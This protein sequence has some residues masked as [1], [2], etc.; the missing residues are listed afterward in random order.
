MANYNNE[1]AVDGDLSY[2]NLYC[3]PVPVIPKFVDIVVNGLNDRLF[4]VN[5]FAEDAISAE[6]RDEFQKM[7]EVEMIARPLFQQIEQDFDLNLFK[8]EESE[9]PESDE[10]LQLYM[11]LKY[12][13]AIEIAAEEAIDTILN[14]NQ[15]N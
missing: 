10:E 3:T 12:K 8:T 4:K 7:I 6:K 1:I 5:A 9:L 14:Q 11:Q 13:P 2:L 15:Y